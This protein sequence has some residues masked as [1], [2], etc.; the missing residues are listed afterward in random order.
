MGDAPSLD[1]TRPEPLRCTPHAE[2]SKMKEY[3]REIIRERLKE[4]FDEQ[5]VETVLTWF[6]SNDTRLPVVVVGAGFTL[7]AENKRTG[8]LASQAEVPLWNDVL[9]R[10]AGD[11]RIPRQGYDA[12]TFAELYYEEMEPA[13]FNSTL[14]D[15]LKDDDLVPGK[16]HK[17][18]FDYPAEAIVTTNNLDKV[19]DQNGR[20]WGTRVVHDPDLALRK[21]TP[22]KPDLIYFHGHRDD[23]TS[24]VFTRGQ[25]EDIHKTRPL[26]VTKVRQLLSQSPVLI[27]GYSL[28]DP[29]FHHI[30]R[31]ISLDMA[32]HH[33]MGLALFPFKRGPSAPERRHWEKLGI[34]IATFKGLY[35]TQDSF[36]KFFRIHPTPNDI[37]TRAKKIGDAV[38]AEPDFEKRCR[39]A[40]DFLS[41]PDRSKHVI[42][43]SYSE[44]DIWLAALRGEFSAAEWKA[45][46]SIYDTDYQYSEYG[47]E[48][49]AVTR[50]DSPSTFK[51]FVVLPR[52]RFGVAD[53]LSR[54]IDAFVF[55][56]P[57][58]DYRLRLARW[59][60][61]ALKGQFTGE[62]KQLFLDLLSWVW[63]SATESPFF[64]YARG[65]A[66]Q[67]IRHALAVA[68]KY[69]Y[70]HVNEHIL[71]DARAIGLDVSDVIQ[72]GVRVPDFVQKMKKGFD[73]ML[74][75]LFQD[76]RK[77]YEE[78]GKIAQ[79]RGEAFEQW[80][81]YRGETDAA[82]A[83][84]GFEDAR[85]EESI[86]IIDR[87]NRQLETY[88]Q[89]P[90]VK[91]WI[92]QAER[93]R[94]RVTTDLIQKF[95]EQRRRQ[96]VGGESFSFSNYPH[97]YW[98]T[99]VD[100]ETIY[101]SPRMQREYVRPLIDLGAF[102]APKELKY[103]LQLRVDET[104]KTEQW[105]L[106]KITEPRISMEEKRKRDEGLV[107]EFTRKGAMRSERLSR[108]DVFAQISDIFRIE[109]LEWAPSFLVQCKSDFG[110]STHDYG[111]FRN[112]RSDYP[113]AWGKY[114]R[115][116]L[117][118]EVID[119]LEGYA[120]TISGE[121]E[122]DYFSKAVCGL[123]LEQWVK[124]HDTAAERLVRLVL[125]IDR[126]FYS[127]SEEI[128]GADE[129]L[130]WALY[131]VMRAVKK[132][133]RPLSSAAL[134]EVRKWS[135]RLLRKNISEDHFYRSGAFNAAVHLAWASALDDENARDAV[136]KAA[137]AKTTDVTMPSHRTNADLEGPI[138]V[139]ISLIDAEVDHAN[140]SVLEVAS[141]LWD[142]IDAQWDE[143]Y[144]FLRNNSHHVWPYAKFFANMI[145][146]A[147]VK[148]LDVARSRLLAMLD[149]A[150]EHLLVCAKVLDPRYWGDH[151]Q[152]FV[153]RVWKS[154]G[155]GD[156]KDPV[157]AKIGAVDLLSPW[158]AQQT[159]VEELS[160]DLGFLLDA[161][162]SAILDQSE[163]LANH[164][165]YN[166]IR[167]AS[168]P[169][170]LTETR[171]AVAALRR[172]AVDPRLA[173]RG[174][175]AYG[176]TRLQTAEVAKDI[177]EVAREI[178]DELSKEKYAVIQRQRRF[179]ELDRD[180]S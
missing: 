79:E 142:S 10:F 90:D 32:Y 83:A 140:S 18:L 93:R 20:R 133:A 50:H 57:D 59:M 118:P 177:R 75:C 122:A 45:I 116:E 58:K 78:A 53:E 48:A 7:N 172:L 134:D 46:S 55:R 151:W 3:R 74:D 165:A 85:K 170:G 163:V 54:Q 169:R 135:A 103:R 76:A 139:W 174:A 124:L 67:T 68:L 51:G 96:S 15:M 119:H 35:S 82:K 155:G 147:L 25:Y 110:D 80:V 97:D 107:T 81:A 137:L 123:P 101:A 14:L 121:I 158:L 152:A 88:E 43:D 31:Q 149:A 145:A 73:S 65:E 22:I 99:F 175:A 91:E 168:K 52:D 166:I 23:R 36:E 111:S 17:A 156:A 12:L 60:T 141:R 64:D 179:G 2:V 69:R 6:I 150:P 176:G 94:T 95:I 146:L 72:W 106:R 178:D 136:V 34:R 5:D 16:A 114:A 153:D 130:G 144:K 173:V 164:A 61:F 66:H 162:F 132:S 167:Y 41:D 56:R 40:E 1:G 157:S 108:L 19:L 29:D 11:L 70:S 28:S 89:A 63:R 26:I 159:A 87:Y 126:K 62:N 129:S 21:E 86:A 30:Y 161:T 109:D 143:L 120:N 49:S 77:A 84:I 128:S 127:E 104:E 98:R 112:L 131:Y 105:I 33:P 42:T 39:R 138:Q 13:T 92:E 102:P 44:Y 115:L 24:W 8:L 9:D 117:R 27:V 171:R 38:R 160:P 4:I 71:E 100:L 37:V 125:D 180:G 154:S 47:N 113:E 148:P